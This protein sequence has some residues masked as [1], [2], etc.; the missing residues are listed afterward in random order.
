MR[1][2]PPLQEGQLQRRYK[3]FLAD[4]VLTDG[5]EITAHCPNPGSML[6]LTTPGARVWLSYTPNPKRKLPYSLEIVEETASATLVGVNTLRTNTLAREALENHTFPSLRAYHTLRR[7]VPYGT[8]SR[9]DFLLE[10]KEEKPIYIEVKNVTLSRQKGLAEF[11]DAV[12]ARGAK[13]MDE[14]YA[15][16]K[17]G[18]R[19][20]VLFLAQRADCTHFTIAQDIDPHYAKALYR[21]L[22]VGVE[23]LAYGCHITPEEIRMETPLIWRELS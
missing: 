3:R 21:A 17:T 18:S 20:V 4:V 5:Q 8:A 1:F 11:P 19:A 9:I 7:E 13:H 2:D 23:I 22:K 16:R 10:H 12:T 14:L 6:G 15:V